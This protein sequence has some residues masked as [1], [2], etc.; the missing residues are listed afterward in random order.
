MMENRGRHPASK[1]PRKKRFVK[2]PKKLWHVGVNA[3]AIPQPKTRDGMRMRWGTLTMR[4]EEK[5]CHKSCATGAM[6]PTIEY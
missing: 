4:M 3:W 1:M 2:R 6:D 5:G